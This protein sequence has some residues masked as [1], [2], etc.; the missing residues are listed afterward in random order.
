[1]NLK[2]SLPGQTAPRLTESP[3]LGPV[4]HKA[5]V[6]VWAALAVIGA[7]LQEDEDAP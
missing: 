3:A 1:M 6:R 5:L 4:A 7:Q 2:H